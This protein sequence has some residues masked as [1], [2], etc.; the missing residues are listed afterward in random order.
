[1][2]R[3]TLPWKALVLHISCSHV[4]KCASCVFLNRQ[5]NQEHQPLGQPSF[6]LLL[7]VQKLWLQ[8]KDYSGDSSS[9]WKKAEQV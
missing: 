7:H 1:M 2:V 9:R 4:Y 3:R 8:K 6:Y 5:D